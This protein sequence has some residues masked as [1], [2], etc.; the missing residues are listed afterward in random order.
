MSVTFCGKLHVERENI[1]HETTLKFLHVFSVT[2]A[3]HKL[4]PCFEKILQRNNVA[5]RMNQFDIPHT[6]QNTPPDFCQYFRNSKTPTFFGMT[7]TK[8]F[9]KFIA[10]RLD[11]ESIRSS[12]KPWKQS[13]WQ[14][15]FPRRKN[16]PL[17]D[18]LFAKLTPSK[19]F[20]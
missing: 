3:T 11:K 5:I 12:L 14:A 1:V 20:S 9:Q 8:P 4:L 13:P 15:F 16:N 17:F 7:I 18:W 10:T 19:Y 2:L 6:S